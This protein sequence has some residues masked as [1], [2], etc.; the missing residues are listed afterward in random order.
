M[1]IDTDFLTEKEKQIFI[2]ILY[3]DED[4]IAFDDFEMGL[5][6]SAIESSM[7][8]HTIPHIP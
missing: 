6:D 3:K 7:I 1:K 4:A 2:N 5:L 8:I